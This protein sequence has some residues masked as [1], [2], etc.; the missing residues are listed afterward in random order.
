MTGGPFG[1]IYVDQKFEHLLE[2]L[3]GKAT[4]REFRMD[5]PAD[6]LRMMNE[7]EMK[8]RGRRAFDGKPTRITLPRS[9]LNQISKPGKFDIAGRLA[10]S[11][12]IEDVEIYND[13]FLCLGPT[14]MKSLFF[15][16]VSGIIG[17]IEGLLRKPELQNLTCLFMVGAF[18]E[19]VIL[20][21]AM[22]TA[23]SMRFPILIP[24]Y[25]GIAVV[26]GAT[27]FGQ[28]PEVI[29][30][31]IMATTYGFGTNNPFNPETDDP[32]KKFTV[33]GVEKCKDIFEIIVRENESVKVGE[34]KSFT[35]CPLYPDQ[36]QVMFPFYTSTDVNV[37]YITDSSVGP[38]IG[39]VNVESPD[40]SLGTKR[41]IELSV[42]FGGTEIKV[43][44]VDKASM[45]TAVVYLDFLC[46]S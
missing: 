9:F 24:N 28:K 20:Q 2:N 3:V 34:K 43:T 13:E 21:E 39:N 22:K 23:F 46:K 41:T 32:L 11:C 5:Y 7:F 4:T 45:N 30:S 44:A 14:V 17:H 10:M 29:S 35:Q 38:S 12:N 27:M 18:A 36:K 8:K 1:G 25:A 31:R 37:K 6:W 42:F 16:V 19:S 40:T 26:Q 33:L 15:P